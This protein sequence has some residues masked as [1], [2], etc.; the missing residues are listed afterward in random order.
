MSGDRIPRFG[1]A[2][3]AVLAVACASAPDDHSAGSIHDGVILSPSVDH[4]AQ[5]VDCHDFPASDPDPDHAYLFVTVPVLVGPDGNVRQVGTPRADRAASSQQILDRAVALARSCTF[6]PAT[7][8]QR[9][10]SDRVDVRFRMSLRGD[11]LSAN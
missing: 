4:P 11:L 5:L 7:I 8:D 10:V 9:P 6:E 3:L 2:V 1:V